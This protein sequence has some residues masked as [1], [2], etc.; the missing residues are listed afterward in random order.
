VS[1]VGPLVKALGDK[2]YEFPNDKIRVDVRQGAA[3]ALGEIGDERAVEPLM[4]AL[5]RDSYVRWSAV[6]AL[7][8]IGKSAVEPLIGVLSDDN[9][10]V[11][12]YAVRALGEIGDERAV[13]PL[14]KAL[15]D[16]ED[17]GVPHDAAKEALKKLGHEVE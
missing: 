16:W 11:R 17:G 14:I 7:G 8:K 13:E 1:L 5:R 3:K 6:V 10:R 12:E 2:N 9:W 4:K 15:G